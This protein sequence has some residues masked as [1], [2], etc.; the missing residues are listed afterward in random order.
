MPEKTLAS[1]G[2]FRAGFGRWSDPGFRCRGNAALMR[3]VA[4]SVRISRPE[5][6]RVG[7]VFAGMTG[8]FLRHL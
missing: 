8:C 2:S 6:T 4:E 7:H 1:G 3:P 5:A